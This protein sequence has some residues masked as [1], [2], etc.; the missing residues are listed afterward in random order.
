MARRAAGGSWADCPAHFLLP[1]RQRTVVAHAVGAHM[2]MRATNSKPPI[3]GSRIEYIVSEKG[4][5]SHVRD[6]GRDDRPNDEIDHRAVGSK[7]LLSSRASANEDLQPANLQGRDGFPGRLTA[8]K[9]AG[10]ARRP[11]A[12]GPCQVRGVES[13]SIGHVCQ[14]SP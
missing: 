4:R 8:L 11:S 1:R 13:L 9:G 7:R 3:V 14:V 5:A 12:R 2:P 6:S 10:T